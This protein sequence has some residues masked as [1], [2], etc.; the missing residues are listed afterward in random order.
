MK[1]SPL[2]GGSNHPSIESLHQLHRVDFSIQGRENLDKIL[3]YWYEVSANKIN[4]EQT[5]GKGI[6]D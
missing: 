1:T 2:F 4:I 6:Q 3:K 5:L